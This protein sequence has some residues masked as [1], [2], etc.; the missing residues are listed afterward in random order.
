MQNLEDLAAHGLEADDRDAAAALVD[1]VKAYDVFTTQV[2]DAVKAGDVARAVRI[3]TVDNAASS[4]KVQADFDT[5]SKNLAADATVIKPRVRASV[6]G[7][8]TILVVLAAVGMAVVAA[9]GFWIIRTVVRPL[10]SV[11]RALAA[12]SEGDLTVRDDSV[13][14]N[15]LARTLGAVL[16]RLRSSLGA[17]G[18]HVETLLAASQALNATAVRMAQTADDTSTRSAQATDA[19]AAVAGDLAAVASGAEEMTASVD[20]IARN[21]GEAATVATEAVTAANVTTE[22]VARLGASSAEIGDVL[23]L[24]TAIAEQ[25]KLLA[26]NATI[27]AARAGEA[28]AGFA[29]VADE[30]KELAN[31]TAHATDEIGARIGAI[32]S[33][34]KA[35]AEA[36]QHIGTVVAR[37][38]DLQGSIAGAVGQQSATTQEMARGLADAADGS[39]RIRD[40]AAGTG[41]AAAMSAQG[42]SETESAA[43]ELSRMAGELHALVSTFKY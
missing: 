24:I 26:L 16:H 33:D 39:S 40:H 21:A 42:A 41:E 43:T 9:A 23:G 29:V 2:Y 6:H 4:N 31:Q 8:M 17:I 32:Q 36:I 19:S 34:A 13:G 1:D 25:T 22:T 27:E 37:I 12:I 5:L 3:V 14:N 28:G 7:W 10:V 11:E 30:V 38:S 35:A 20:E 15:R 18:Q